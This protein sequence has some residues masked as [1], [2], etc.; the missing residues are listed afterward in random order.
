VTYYESS[1]E[2]KCSLPVVCCDGKCGLGS[3]ELHLLGPVNA[4]KFDHK[5]VLAEATI[6]L[7]PTS[8][9]LALIQRL[10]AR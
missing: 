10:G 2:C 9:N 3:L 8:T 7:S 4:L 5:L 6:G 1:E